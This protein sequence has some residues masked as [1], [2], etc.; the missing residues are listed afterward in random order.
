MA[1]IHA[2]LFVAVASDS[3]K[4]EPPPHRRGDPFE[5]VRVAGHDEIA[6][7]EHADD[8][9]GV[10]HVTRPG[11]SARS[12]CQARHSLIEHLDATASQQTGQR[13]LRAA[14]PCLPENARRDDRALPALECTQV[15]RP[16]VAAP[17]LGSEQRSRV[18][19]QDALR[20]RRWRAA[21]SRIASA[22]ASS[23][24]VKPPCR[25]SHSRTARR[26]SSIASA[27]RAA[28]SSHAERLI[29]SCLAVA[30]AARATAS[31]RATES[32]LTDMVGHGT[33][34]LLPGQR[35]ERMR[36]VEDNAGRRARARDLLG[37]K[38]LDHIVV[39]DGSFR[40]LTQTNSGRIRPRFV[41]S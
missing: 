39:G 19:R 31:S 11:S 8:D 20:L 7:G 14:A 23:S 1:R 4:G 38:V 27:S 16:D 2:A 5:V 26:P 21:R 32:F 15:Q 36:S 35:G 30:A 18:V 41:A 3:M 25:R 12:P 22:A 37:I 17:R 34:R 9:A 6:A 40:L 13:G 29:P 10:D 33:T 24:R 28:R